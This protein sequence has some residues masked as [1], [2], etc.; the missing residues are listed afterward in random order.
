MN[1]TV[2]PAA[3]E[4]LPALTQ[5]YN[6][7]VIHTH[8]T[9][10][11]EPSTVEQRLPWFNDHNDGHRYRML[12]A[13]EAGRVLGCTFSG[14]FR[15]KPAYDTTVEVGIYCHPDAVGRGLGA[16]LYGSLYDALSGQD[17]NRIVAGIAQ[18]NDASNA[19]HHKMGFRATGTFTQVGR[20]F[21]KYWDVAWLERPLKLGS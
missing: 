13:C 7:Y 8:I 18:P 16:I 6:H 20:K 11:L 1:V 12:V 2:R 15:A 14:R 21:G 9:F 10:D 5:I 17:I 4:D 19:L 3:L